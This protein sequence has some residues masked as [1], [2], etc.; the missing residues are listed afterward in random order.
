M[1]LAGAC[2][3]TGEAPVFERDTRAFG[4]VGAKPDFHLAGACNV[5]LGHAAGPDM[6][7]KDYSFRRQPAH[8]AR[9]IEP[10][11]VGASLPKH[12]ALAA[13]KKQILERGSRP[14]E[15]PWP[16]EKNVVP[17]FFERDGGAD[18]NS[19][20]ATQ[21]IFC[22]ECYDGRSVNC[23][24]NLP[25]SLNRIRIV[26]E[27][28]V[29]LTLK[30]CKQTDMNRK[31]SSRHHE[32][33]SSS[34]WLYGIHAVRAA[35]ANPRRKI[36]RAVLTGRAAEELGHAAHD[37]IKFEAAQTDTVSRLLPAGAVHQ[38]AALLCDPLPN[39]ELSDA[40][41]R[42]HAP[43]LICVLDQI[44]DP[45]NAGAILRS[46]A[47]F[48]IAAVIVQDRHA[49]PE[50]GALAK[51]ASGALDSVPYVRVVNI[52]RALEQMRE[53]GVWRVALAGDGEQTLQDAAVAGDMAIVLGSEGA[54]LRRLVRESCDIA[55]YIPIRNEMESLNVSNAA[56][57]AFYELRRGQPRLAGRASA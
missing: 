19:D 26:A 35:L 39:V 29:D 37:R 8:H 51:A 15:L 48:G 7:T 16:P 21:C 42:A 3:V 53:L 56:A 44:T 5:R 6:P 38:G 18:R 41:D 23:H 33:P 50:S 25:P 54:G 11:S 49:P 14:G 52:A 45:H 2:T 47:A 31:Y 13:L 17:E 24:G 12:S 36:R 46:A 32:A 55:A 9:P 57:V 43:R 28:L 4:P 30:L 34:V 40:L 1:I 27:I 20:I 22:I 10:Q